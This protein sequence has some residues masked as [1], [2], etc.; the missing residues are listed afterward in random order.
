V[1]TSLLLPQEPIEVCRQPA[2]ALFRCK[3]R[4]RCAEVMMVTDGRRVWLYNCGP[5]ELYPV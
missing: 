5:A 2:A 1:L 4:Y 3:G